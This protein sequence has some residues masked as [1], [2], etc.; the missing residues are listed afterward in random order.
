[1]CEHGNGI[2]NAQLCQEMGVNR[3]SERQRSTRL[4]QPA[5]GGGDTQRPVHLQIM[6]KLRILVGCQCADGLHVAM[7]AFYSAYMLTCTIDILK[8]R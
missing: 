8:L 7:M 3:F 2:S 4:T 1:M 6:G 5:P